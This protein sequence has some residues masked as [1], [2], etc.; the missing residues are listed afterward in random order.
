MDF[1]LTDSGLA[2][3]S[4]HHAAHT[5]TCC[6]IVNNV[7]QDRGKT[8][9]SPGSYCNIFNDRIQGFLERVVKNVVN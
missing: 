1:M 3:I 4:L 8:R 6:N 7:Q 9:F 5:I 2:G